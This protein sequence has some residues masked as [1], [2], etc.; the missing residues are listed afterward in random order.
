M[1]FAVPAHAAAPKP[2]PCSKGYV[3]LSFDDGPTAKTAT[4][5]IA[6]K[7]AGLRATFFDVG[8]RAT[9]LPSQ[10]ATKQ[11]D[12]HVVANHSYDHSDLVAIGLPAATQQLIRTQSILT[13]LAGSAPTL[14]RPPYGSTNS[15]LKDAAAAL[16]LTEII[17]TVDTEDWS[18]V[19]TSSIVSSVLKVKPGGFVLMH[20][21]YQ[22][23]I[24]AI[25]RIA[26]G[27]ADRG[28]CAGKIIYSA[29]PT[30]SWDGGPQFNATVAPWAASSPP[31]A[32]GMSALADNF[33]AASLDFARWDGSSVGVVSQSGGRAR[34]PCTTSYPTIGT[35]TA[36]DLTGTGAFARMIAPPDGNGSREAFLVLSGAAGN[37]FEWGR[38]GSGLVP[39]F[40]AGGVTTDGPAFTYDA[41]AHAWWRIRSD[42]G[43]IVWETSSDGNAWTNR[44][45]VPTPFTITAMTVNLVCGYWGTETAATLEVDSFNVVP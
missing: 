12:G 41:L 44:W 9:A 43:T 39:R 34:V 20:D 25:P 14:Y 4:L 26:T 31:P 40:S 27:L 2:A 10:Y 19:S 24:N 6:L 37:K 32:T 22:N 29:T 5:L 23:T 3:S 42:A 28:L 8:Q 18:G 17:W 36:R 33:D 35:N 7:K 1:A 11:V 15:E 13:P 38:S 21:G 30:V 45:S 16:G